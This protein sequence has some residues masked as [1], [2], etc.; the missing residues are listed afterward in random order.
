[1]VHGLVGVTCTLYS[2]RYSRCYLILDIVGVTC[3]EL[4]IVGVTCTVL[5]IV[6]V[7]CT[8]L[9]IVGVTCTELDIVGEL[10]MIMEAML[11][12]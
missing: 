8:E 5:D 7:T 6:G 11:G 3:T 12:D 2:T 9:D 10:G 4:D 1:M